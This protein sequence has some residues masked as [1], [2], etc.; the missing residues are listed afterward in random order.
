MSTK[1]E[2]SL[3]DA[4]NHLSRM[5]TQALGDAIGAHGV[6]PGQLPVL[7]CLWEDDGLTQRELYQR[8]HIE[9]AT[10]SNT[11]SRMERDGLV[12]RKPDPND[13]RAARVMLTTKAKKLEPK[14][15]DAAKAV[16]KMALGAI[17][18]KEKKVLQALIHTMIENLTP[19]P[20]KD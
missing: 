14:L 3:S 8:V 15:A 12:T 5:M 4:V 2:K 19:V 1:S 16:N 7:M 11:L 13:R 10:M 17:K 18:K 9:Q 6:T 20:D